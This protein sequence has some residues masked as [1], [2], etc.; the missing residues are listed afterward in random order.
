[1]CIIKGMH[2][3]ECINTFENDSCD[4]KLALIQNIVLVVMII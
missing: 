1:M 3:D 2:K 4:L